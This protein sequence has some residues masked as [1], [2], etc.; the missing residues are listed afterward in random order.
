MKLTI[1][2][3]PRSSV[4]LDVELPAARLDEALLDAVRRLSRR[5][6]VPGFRP[7]KA[8]R[9]MLERVLGPGSVLEEA[10]EQ[11]VADS[12]RIAIRDLK[13]VPLANPDLEVLKAEEGEPL[14]Y[15]ATVQVRP[16]IRLGDYRNF[17]FRPEIETTDDARVDKVLDEL[18]D[19]NAILEPVEDRPVAK[20]DYVV[21]SFRGTRDG[22]AFEGGASERMPMI[23]G[24]DRLVP[25]FEDHLIG[26][27]VGEGREFDVTFPDDYAEPS[28]AGQP[29]HFSVELKEHRAKV[30]PD[31]DDEFAR[32]L[33]PYETLAALRVVIRRR[34][35]RNALDK[36]RHEFADR[37][38]E[39]AVANATLELPETVA[40][41]RDADGLPPILVEQETEV[42]HDEFRSSLAR[43]GI[44]DEAYAKVTGQGHED[45]HNEFRPQ[46][47]KRVKVLLVLSKVAEAEG[48]LVPDRDVEAEVQRARQRYGD[49]KKLVGYFDSERG[50]N[51]IR[52]TQ[53][54]S[55]MVEKLV[56]EWLAA[57]PE[58]PALPHADDDDQRSV[59]E[60]AAAAASAAMEVTDPG[61][62][63][64]LNADGEFAAAA[65]VWAAAGDSASAGALAAAGASAGAAPAANS[66]TIEARPEGAA[67]SGR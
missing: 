18:R 3:A 49:N 20:E 40:P 28:L 42:L 6:R 38:I 7:G 29:A 16:V 36:A 43:Q 27:K 2:P 62:V 66:E 60:S 25:G 55:R 67:A 17:N 33:G 46:A 47:E 59:V 11:A 5:T 30:L 54:R 24:S 1:T 32:Q 61:L 23:V 52:S 63:Q 10:V 58:H 34:L 14:T 48:V 53:R 31:L 56:D 35:E 4:T 41:H 37:I 64:S 22:E 8:P 45:L 15:R 12:Y 65:G 19:Q 13:V 51:F 44:T 26:L 21:I 9:F 39:Y 50:R 57:H